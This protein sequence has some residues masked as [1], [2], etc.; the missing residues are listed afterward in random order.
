MVVV[1]LDVITYSLNCFVL[2]E[3][4]LFSFLKFHFSECGFT[5]LLAQ[6]L[7]IGFVLN[8]LIF[9]LNYFIE[10]FFLRSLCASSLAKPF[11]TGS[12]FEN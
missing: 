8:L 9:S 3:G 6:P 12:E 4:G 2:L 5:K 7:S 10:E 1:V 11:F